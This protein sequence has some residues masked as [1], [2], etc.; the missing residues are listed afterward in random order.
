MNRKLLSLVIAAAFVMQSC[1]TSGSEILALVNGRRITKKE[2]TQ[3][4]GL[5]GL[6]ISGEEEI[7]GFLNLLINDTVILDQAQKDGMK[8]TGAELAQEI[9]SFVPGFSEKEIRKSLKK[10]GIKYSYWLR[11]IEEKI[12]RKKEIVFVM[13]NRIKIEENDLKDYFWTNILDFRKQKKIRARQI[14]LDSEDKAKEVVK[15]AREGIDFA[16]LAKKY[17]TTSE[18]EDGGDMG[19]F[20]P[21]E[22]PGFINDAIAGLKKGDISTIVRSAYG[23]HIFKIEDITEASTPVFEEARAEV[24]ERYFD[25]KKDEYFGAWMEELRK[26]ANIRI[27]EENLKKFVKEAVK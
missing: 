4:A 24:L 11:D 7:K 22:M 15:L 27:N 20:S 9:G 5:Y 16:G 25:A 26:K 14:V 2:F 6:K 1:G 13:K 23:W 21:G 10:Q 8:V 3:K 18:A 12:T 19:Y 17:S